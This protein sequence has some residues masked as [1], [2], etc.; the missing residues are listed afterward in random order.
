MQL[1]VDT[2]SAVTS[3]LSSLPHAELAGRKERVM[4]QCACCSHFVMRGSPAAKNHLCSDCALNIGR[5]HTTCHKNQVPL[6][7][8]RV[9]TAKIEDTLHEAGAARRKMGEEIRDGS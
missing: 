5:G 1:G 2:Q 7:L 6:I 4:N 9:E 3:R 8:A